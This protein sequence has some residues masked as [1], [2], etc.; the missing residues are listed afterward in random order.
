MVRSLSDLER[1]RDDLSDFIEFRR[2]RDAATMPNDLLGILVD[3]VL[4][5]DLPETLDIRLDPDRRRPARILEA[6]GLFGIWT[7]CRFE[8]PDDL[9]HLNRGML[10]DALL[11]VP[12][13]KD[14]DPLIGFIPVLA[15]GSGGG[16]ERLESSYRDLVLPPLYQDPVSGRLYYPAGYPEPARLTH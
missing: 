13:R 3:A 4:V 6:T 9:P 15:S 2:L 14:Q 11:A 12:G 16:G 8:I 10:L 5:M 7:L 1:C